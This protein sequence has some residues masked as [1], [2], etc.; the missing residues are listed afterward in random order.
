MFANRNVFGM[1]TLVL[2]VSQLLPLIK[3]TVKVLF[4][5]EKYDGSP[6]L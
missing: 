1:Q 6:K 3:N 4:H 2:T 5:V